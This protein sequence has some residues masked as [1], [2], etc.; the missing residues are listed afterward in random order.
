MAYTITILHEF[1]L[2]YRKMTGIY[3]D[4]QARATDTEWRQINRD[5]D[6]NSY[7]RLHDLTDVTYIKSPWSRSDDLRNIT[8]KSLSTRSYLLEK[9]LSCT[10]ARRFWYWSCL[11]GTSRILNSEIQRLPSVC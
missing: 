6:F 3:D 1:S 4:N 2:V 5:G 8:I 7:N 11:S 9:R 10:L